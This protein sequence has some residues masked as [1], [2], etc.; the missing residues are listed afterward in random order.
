[1][2]TLTILK[3]AIENKQ[4]ISFEYIKEDEVS[5]VRYGN[6]HAVFLNKTTDNPTADIYQTDWA[7]S[8]KQQIP[9][10]RPFILDSI[11]NIQLLDTTFEIAQ[12]YSSN[13][14][15]GRYDKVLAKIQ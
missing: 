1:M 8:T 14:K 6:P 9:G 12:G 3:T 15:S 13:P 7:S 10:W 4:Q 11:Q 5:G 2:T